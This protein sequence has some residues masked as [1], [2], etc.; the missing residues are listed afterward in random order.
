[1]IRH[2][3]LKFDAD[4]VVMWIHYVDHRGDHGHYYSPVKIAHYGLAALNDVV[5]GQGDDALRD[6]RLHLRWIMENYSN[7]LG[8]VVWRI[9]STSPKYELGPNFASSIAQGLALSLLA[10]ADSD[11]SRTLAGELSEAALAPLRIRVEDGGLLGNGKWGPCFEE[12]PCVPYSHVVNGFVFCLNGIYDCYSA[13]GMAAARELFEIGLNTLRQM[14]SVWFVPGWAR[15]DLRDLYTGGS[16]NLATRHYQYLH[17]DQLKGLAIVTDD[18]F[19]NR[20]ARR[21]EFQAINPVGIAY[22]YWCKAR[23]VL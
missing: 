3:N 23:K 17:A 20:L 1:M 5:N 21:I 7:D 10:R 8:G 9:P 12:Y 22:A 4:G 6:Y 14:T 15:Y 19:W 2:Y 11:H 13:F 18:P 16:P